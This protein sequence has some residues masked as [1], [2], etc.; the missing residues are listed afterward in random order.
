MFTIIG[1]IATSCFKNR[2]NQSVEE[3]CINV[4]NGENKQLCRIIYAFDFSF[5]LLDDKQLFSSPYHLENSLK[6]ICAE[7]FKQRPAKDGYI[8][9]ILG[10]AMK[11]HEYLKEHCSK[12]DESSGTV[13]V[14]VLGEIFKEK[15]FDSAADLEKIV[16]NYS[17]YVLL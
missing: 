11:L 1:F 17:R 6:R 13:L 3:F 5:T 2:R 15:G 14:R 8:I 10:Y 12:S 16:N 4:I 9:A 7:L